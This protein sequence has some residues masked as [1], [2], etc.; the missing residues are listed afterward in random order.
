MG[1]Q[2]LGLNQE[3]QAAVEEIQAAGSCGTVEAVHEERD[4]LYLAV[5]RKNGQA[6]VR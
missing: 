4:R 6:Y 5:G 2:W 1:L 3:E